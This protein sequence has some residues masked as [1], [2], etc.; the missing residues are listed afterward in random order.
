MSG[1]FDVTAHE[2]L[3][4]TLAAELTHAGA[5]G[6]GELVVD[7]GAVTF[8]DAGT[9][10]VL[11]EAWQTA[12]DAGMRLR[13]TAAEG[14][15]RQVIEACTAW[16]RLVGDG[17]ADLARDGDGDGAGGA[18]GW[19]V[20]TVDRP[21]R[22]AA[23]PQRTAGEGRGRNQARM[24]RIEARRQQRTIDGELR[25]TRRAMVAALATRLENDPL[26]ITRKEFLAVADL[27]AVLDAIIM[28]A[29][30]VGGADA[31]ALK[32]FDD[33]TAAPR[34]TRGASLPMTPVTH[35]ARPGPFQSHQL[36]DENGRILGVLSM[37]YREAKPGRGDGLVAWGA[38]R[39]L[40][41]VR[42]R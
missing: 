36:Y 7:L 40:R 25:E 39:A 37:Y 16:D 4:A 21:G 28:V 13:A 8:L 42:G 33:R 38:A 35:E 24:H 14:A 29:T 31:C 15:A 10:G 2:P 41:H 27:P 18:S 11:L 32:T 19:S 6:C 22:P 20:E 34:I 5:R 9:V 26:A 30:V 17:T 23:A 1:V 12:A 3:R